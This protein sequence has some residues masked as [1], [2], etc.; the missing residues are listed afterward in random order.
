[1]QQ[2][3]GDDVLTEHLDGPFGEHAQDRRAVELVGR[4]GL[5]PRARCRRAGDA[6][7]RRVDEYD[8]RVAGGVGGRDHQQRG[9]V[10]ELVVDRD[11]D[12]APGQPV[13]LEP[14]RGS[15]RERRAHLVERRRDEQVAADDPRDEHL[16]LLR[17]T[18]ADQ[19][20]QPADQRLAEGQVERAGADLAHEHSHLG[21]SETLAAVPGRSGQ[22]Q[23]PGLG[24]GGPAG[25][26]LL[27]AL[28]DHVGEHR[29]DL[30][31]RGIAG[32]SPATSSLMR[33]LSRVKL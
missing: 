18:A 22:P 25:A 32:E 13:V 23:Q 8:D 26:D 21:E 17:R 27:G 15:L 24:T 2:R 31:A 16:L 29:T 9:G 28:L 1:M 14:G 11:R 3:A 30:P 5:A 20:E 19:G 12:L 33:A 4:L 7:A 6:V 10:R